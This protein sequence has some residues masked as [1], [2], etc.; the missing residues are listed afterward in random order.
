MRDVEI[1]SNSDELVEAI[2]GQSIELLKT[3]ERPKVALSGGSLGIKI[4]SGLVRALNDKGELDRYKFFMADERFVSEDDE[5]SNLGQIRRQIGD[6]RPDFFEFLLPPSSAIEDSANA[7]N[8]QLEAEFCF[9]LALLGCGPDGHTA[10]LFPG[11]SYPADV[12]V[13]EAASPKPPAQ[14]LSF[15]YRVFE[16]SSNVWFAASGQE[17]ATAVSQA[18]SGNENLPVGKIT[19]R[20]TKWFITE[21]LA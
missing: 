4:A 1:H 19:G 14:R 10:S 6:L 8:N 15:G 7:A 16:A 11:H 2:I 3:V 12:V 9:D 5:Q 20:S 13:V 18:L 17:K 21:E